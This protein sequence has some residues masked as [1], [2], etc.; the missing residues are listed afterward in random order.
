MEEAP[1]AKVFAYRV[2]FIFFLSFIVFGI[3]AYGLGQFSIQQL[4]S[5]SMSAV[6]LLALTYLV[7]ASF[8]IYIGMVYYKFR[9]VVRR[10]RLQIKFFPFT[11]SIRYDTVYEID[12]IPY[13]NLQT[14]RS[15]LILLGNS[16]IAIAGKKPVLYIKRMEG[17]I[18]DFYISSE[19][20]EQLISRI[21]FNMKK[22]FAPRKT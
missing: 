15:G 8:L 14:P 4:F 2:I 18:T 1:F 11:I 6:Q 7:V 17:I 12:L 21:K 22:Y 19:Y 16:L 13:E 5:T 20:P 3:L 9:Y 10:D